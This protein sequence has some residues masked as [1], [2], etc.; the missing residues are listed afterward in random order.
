[1]LSPSPVPWPSG[2]GGEERLEACS[3]TSGVMPEPVSVTASIRT[4]PASLGVPRRHSRRR[5]TALPASIVSLPRAGHR[6]ARVDR[7]VK[8]RVLDLRRID[9]RVPK[10][11][12]R[13][14]VSISILS[15]SARRSISSSP[16]T[17]RPR[18]RT[19]GASGWRRPKAKSCDASLEPRDTPAMRVADTLLGLACCRQRPSKQLQ[20]AA[21][22][23]QQVVEVVRDAAGQLAHRFHLLGHGARILGLFALFGFLEKPLVCGRQLH[24]RLGYSVFERLIELDWRS[25]LSRKTSSVRWRLR[26]S[27]SV[28]QARIVDGDSCLRRQ[29]D[30]GAPTGW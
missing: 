6:V 1:M 19:F 30:G 13:S 4:V 14:T 10:T 27:A 16:R 24:R 18:L 28:V 17:S 21:D 22:D 3:I 8:Q 7:K 15:P 12:R 9:E 2:L 5:E 25:S 29:F 26:F 20:V 11:R 23:L